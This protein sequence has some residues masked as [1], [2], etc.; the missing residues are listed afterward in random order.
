MRVGG[1]CVG[2]GRRGGMGLAGASCRVARAVT[3]WVVD[4][5]ARSDGW[6]GRMGVVCKAQSGV[7]LG[8]GPAH[9]VG[10]PRCSR[11][12]DCPVDR[13]GG[14]SRVGWGGLERHAGACRA[15]R[16][17]TQCLD[18][19]SRVGSSGGVVWRWVVGCGS[20]ARGR[21]VAVV[22]TDL[23][24]PCRSVDVGRM[25][26]AGTSVQGRDGRCRAR[27]VG[28]VTGRY[29]GW[30]GLRVGI[31][32]VGR[33]ELACRLGRWC[34]AVRRGVGR[35]GVGRGEKACRIGPGRQETS[36]GGG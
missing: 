32:T 4:G 8:R 9:G 1:G 29:V 25:S 6:S 36:D 23:D 31:S 12:G 2:W 14:A 17:V 30:G 7:V 13:R 18:G 35:L 5:G 11:D 28:R 34:H 3:G 15:L 24:G 21:H 20:G 26:G 19:R 22:G 16:C 10:S 33:D 27:H